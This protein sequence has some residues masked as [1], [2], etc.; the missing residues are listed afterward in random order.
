MLAVRDRIE[1]RGG[2]IA[3]APYASGEDHGVLPIDVGV[4]ICDVRVLS[5][6]ESG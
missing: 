1:R 5:L 4:V 3:V 6:V 2:R